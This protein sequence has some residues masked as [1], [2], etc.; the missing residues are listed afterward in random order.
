MRAVFF[1]IPGVYLFHS[2][3]KSV[4]ERVSWLL[5]NP[6]VIGSVAI[7]VTELSFGA[8]LSALLLSFIAWQSV[9]ET[10]YIENDIITTQKEKT[11]TLRLDPSLHKELERS[12]WPIVFTKMAL[13]A[14]SCAGL[15]AIS[16][17]FPGTL[18][19][20]MF[21]G[22]IFFSRLAFYAHN[23]TRSRLNVVTYF[24][25]SGLK[26]SSI[27]VLFFTGSSLALLILI[28]ILVFPLPRT[29]EHAC[30]VKYGFRKLAY[31]IVPFDFFRPKYYFIVAIG[32]GVL[33]F[34]TGVNEFYIGTFVA[35]YFFLLRILGLA[36][37]F[38]L[39]RRPPAAYKWGSPK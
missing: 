24:F 26:Y 34:F 10:G 18:A 32:L 27:P 2:R 15:A 23:K 4:T 5:I 3:L 36:L 7:A 19:V 6:V 38:R 21:V 25:L 12:Y 28:I 1:V 39:D 33:A 29:L 22:L 11:P 14:L 8:F 35:I 20:G 16:H 30:K 37:S 13:A 9:Y 31:W 17:S